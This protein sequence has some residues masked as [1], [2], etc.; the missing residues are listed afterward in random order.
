MDFVLFLFWC[1]SSAVSLY[2]IFAIFTKALPVPLK[3]IARVQR[4]VVVIVP[5]RTDFFSSK[6]SKS[7]LSVLNLKRDSVQSCVMVL[8]T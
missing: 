5:L 4:M 2:Y 8:S 1:G 3:G 7:F 6:V